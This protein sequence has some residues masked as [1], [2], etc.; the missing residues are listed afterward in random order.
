[1]KYR[2][3]ELLPVDVRS[4]VPM[5]GVTIGQEIAPG[6]A[7]SSDAEIDAFMRKTAIT[8]HHPAGTCRMGRDDDPLAVV[9][10]QLRV[11]GT[12]GLRI[13]DGSVMP[14][15]TSGNINAPIIMIAERA[16][17]LIRERVTFAAR[18]PETTEAQ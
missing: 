16:A 12:R 18:T 5:E 8:V 1:M 15:L 7:R 2:L 9:D 17:D 10:A 13:V 3:A 11:H 6:P 4:Q 14:D